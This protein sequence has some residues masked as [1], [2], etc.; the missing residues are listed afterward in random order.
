MPIN[1]LFI[2]SHAI[3]IIIV[4][5][6]CANTSLHPFSNEHYRSL[7]FKAVPLVFYL[8]ASCPVKVSGGTPTSEEGL[9]AG[10]V[11]QFDWRVSRVGGQS[12]ICAVI[13]KQPDDRKVVARHCVMKRPAE[14]GKT[15]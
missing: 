14:E 5:A 8:F 3:I 10:A 13:Q 4:C 7:S 12:R 11:G 1:P 2:A 6:I 15:G 9:H